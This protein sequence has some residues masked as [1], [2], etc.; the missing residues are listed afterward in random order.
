MILGITGTDGAGK[1]TV[2]AYLVEQKRFVHKHVRTMLLKEADKKGL[3]HDRESMRLVANMLRKDNGDDFV[4]RRFLDEARE[5]RLTNVIVDS[6]RTIAEAECLKAAGGILLAIDADQKLRYERITG[7]NSESDHVTFEEFVRQEE[8]E[9]NDSDPHGMQ[10]AAVMQMADY[11]LIN[12]GS[13]EE[14]H[15]DIERLLHQIGV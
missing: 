15:T 4:V 6:V 9:N 8:L 3:P 10:K 1:S 14:L 7:R 5:E 11:H 2:V 13:L 12:N